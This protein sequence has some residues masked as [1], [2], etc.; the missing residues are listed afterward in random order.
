MQKVSGYFPKN[1]EKGKFI[2]VPELWIWKLGAYDCFF[3]K[4]ARKHDDQGEK[5]AHLFKICQLTGIA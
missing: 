3:Y 5:I 1:L 2:A 4:S